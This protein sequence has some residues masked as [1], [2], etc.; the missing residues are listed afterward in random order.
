MKIFLRTG[1]YSK[2]SRKRDGMKIITDRVK[3]RLLKNPRQ[4]KS[5]AQEREGTWCDIQTHVFLRHNSCPNLDLA[6]LGSMPM[7]TCPIDNYRA[8]FRHNSIS[9]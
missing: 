5:C 4:V 6:C 9:Y 8:K 3:S 1:G 2:V 7:V